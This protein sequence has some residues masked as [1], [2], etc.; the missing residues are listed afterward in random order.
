MPTMSNQNSDSDN[1]TTSSMPCPQADCLIAAGLQS[2]ILVPRDEGYAAR[3][4]SYWC[5]SAK[6]QPACIV[7]PV[8]SIEVSKALKA[9]A[10]ADQAFAVRGGGHSNW[11]GSNNID[12]GVTIDLGL[13]SSTTYDPATEQAHI[14]PGAKWKN[15][16][17]EL[18]KHGRVV[19]GGREGEVGVAGFL[20]GGGNTFYTMRYGL[21]CDNVLAYEVV[22]SDGQIITADASGQNADLFRVLKGGGNN[23][24][25]VTRFT[26]R[27]LPSGPIW[28]G[29]AVKPT[30]VMPEAAKAIEDFVTNSP[31]DPDSSLNFTVCHMPR[32]G[33][34]VVVTILN[35]VAGVS[36]P[37]AFEQ[38]SKMPD[39][40]NNIKMTTLEEI[41]P[42]A[43]LPTDY[44]NVWYTLCFKNDAS[45][46]A[47]AD[48]LHTQLASE[49]QEKVSDG[50]FTT[51]CSFQ[52][53]PKA[54]GQQ[55]AAM[56]G[57]I[58]G[59]DKYAH[60]AIMIQVN[61]SVR[62]RELADWARPRV[63]G[64][65]DNIRAFAETIDDGVAPWLYMN[66]ASPDQEV[67][68]SYGPDNV[69]KMKEAA[70]KYDPKGVFQRL[71]PGGFKISTIKD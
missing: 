34:G 62:T 39:L 43:S 20:L 60:D 54:V 57:N 22:L 36:S 11:A 48:E 4:D 41:L 9:L 61:A 38:F 16:Y 1:M 50:D 8:S 5:N 17:A 66:Y 25:I 12:G 37:P 40:M 63:R 58:L 27:T 71:C 32:F 24:G 7:Q 59:L 13:L 47:K 21:A 64:V 56:G 65:V 44:Y 14:S 6:L 51:H 68:Q 28:G 67:L 53:I 26:M 31:S 3:I 18:E 46:I 19:A 35:N 15:V 69:R 2:R 70:I 30:T 52:P 33:G 55:S 45:I 10:D 49:V 29:F 42:Y 23:F